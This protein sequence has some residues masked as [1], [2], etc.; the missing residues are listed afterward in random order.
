MSL[1]NLYDML[2]LMT[3]IEVFVMTEEA[4]VRINENGRVVIAATFRK[5][6]AINPGDE[7]TKLV[8][9]SW[10]PDEAWRAATGLI[11]E[12]MPFEEEH[13]R[14]AGNLTITHPPTGPFL[15]RS[16]NAWRWR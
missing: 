6:L 14:I 8:M 1:Q 11:S 15:G 16:R 4:R 3:L 13:A 9:H 2:M 5:A 12:V 7:V 10:R